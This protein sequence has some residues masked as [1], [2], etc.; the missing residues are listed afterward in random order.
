[1]ESNMDASCFD[2]MD[3]CNAEQCV[4]EMP[5]AEEAFEE[6]FLAC[7]KINMNYQIDKNQHLKKNPKVFNR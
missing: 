1:M 2:A 3:N 5:R 6:A 4:E 7:L